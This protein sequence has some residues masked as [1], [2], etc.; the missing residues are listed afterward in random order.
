MK[1]Q[2]LKDIKV[3]RIPGK[4]PM[5]PYWRIVARLD[6]AAGLKTSVPEVEL[7]SDIDRISEERVRR[8]IAEHLY[9]EVRERLLEIRKKIVEANMHVRT[10]RTGGTSREE[11]EAEVA[12][13]ERQIEAAE[14]ALSQISDL[15]ELLVGREVDCTPA[16]TPV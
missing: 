8:E 6:I 4:A 15:L 1:L 11:F 16:T 12:N 5:D 7:G 3:E 10:A 2:P 14:Q 13:R 9:G